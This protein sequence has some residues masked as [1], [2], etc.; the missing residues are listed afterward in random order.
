MTTRYDAVFFDFGGTLFSYRD[1]GRGRPS[2]VLEAVKRLGVEASRREIG[3][4][5]GAAQRDAFVEY[6]RRDFYLHRHLFQAT[7][8][9]FAGRLGVEPTE[10]FL[11]WFHEAQREMLVETFE[12]RGDCLDTL[13]ALRERGHTVSI[14]SNIDDD[15]LDPMVERSGLAGILHHWT[16]S[17]EA[18]SCKPH[19]AVFRLALEKAGCEP[20]RVLFVGDSRV[21][22]VAGANA[23]GM[24]SVLIVEEGASVPGSD[25]DEE[26]TPHHE[27]S[28]LS[29]LL[30]LVG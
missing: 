21:H 11:D 26:A 17:E 12:L 6:N 5:Y 25:P 20:E 23:L 14:V 28:A 19:E 2:V 30:G 3:K 24:T 16:S 7:F 18:S 8:A 9:G 13:R 22:D 15:Y 10:E 4:A 27:I 29:E 1:I